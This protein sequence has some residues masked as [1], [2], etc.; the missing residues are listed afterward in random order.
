VSNA[1]KF[2]DTGSIKVSVAAAGEPGLIEL[3]VADTGIG[4]TAEQAERIF[5]P[6]VQADSSTTRQFGG[7]G[8]G[9]SICRQLA[10]MMGGRIWVDSQPGVGSTFHVALRLALVSCVAGCPDHGVTIQVPV[11][12]RRRFRVLLVDDIQENAE[13][14]EVRLA[15]QGHR[16]TVARDGREAVDL[17]RTQAFDVILMDV[18]MP[19]MSGLDATREIRRREDGAGPRIPIIAMTASVLPAERHHCFEAGMTDFIVKPVNFTALFRLLEKV[20]PAGSGEPVRTAE[21]PLHPT[22]PT[23]PPLDGID[24]TGGLR[25]WSDADRYR[26]ALGSFAARYADTARRLEAF[27]AAGNWQAAY[28]LAHALK[29]VSGNLS[30]SQVAHFAGALTDAFKR[31]RSD[32]VESLIPQLADALEVAAASIGQ[33]LQSS[34]KPAGDSPRK[35]D[36]PAGATVAPS[37][38]LELLAALETDDP[39]AVEPVLKRVSASLLPGDA[40]QVQG[41]IDDFEFEGARNFVATLTGAAIND[42]DHV[43]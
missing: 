35:P 12:S 9:V 13:L 25:R 3:T 10:E 40:A 30:I 7:T 15:A 29:G 23:L 36:S 1:I 4:M 19:V 14:G 8:L 32:G 21:V 16:V 41:L 6:F 26:A 18:R 37:A 17:A 33:L 20:V 5:T 24:V 42:S 31:R 34:R 43:R 38:L 2:T 28:E 22:A 11:Q 27:Q 39:G